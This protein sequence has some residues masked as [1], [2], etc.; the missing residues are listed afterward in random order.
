MKYEIRCY[1]GKRRVAT[2]EHKTFVGMVLD[3]VFNIDT[4]NLSRVKLVIEGD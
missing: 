2:H 4:K 1:I 3:Y